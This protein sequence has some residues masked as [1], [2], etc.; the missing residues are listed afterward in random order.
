MNESLNSRFIDCLDLEK[1]REK[2]TVRPEPVGNLA[3]LD[4]LIAAD[5]F[6]SALKSI[7]IP[8]EFCLSFIKEMSTQAWLHSQSLFSSEQGYVSRIY[9]P[10]DIE[11]SPVCLTGLAGVGKSQTIAAL[12]KV[13]PPPMEFSCDHFNSNIELISYWYASARGK[14][15]GRQM[16]SDFLSSQKITSRNAA[17]LLVDCRRRVNRDG[18]SMLILEETQHISTGNGASKVTD[19][20]LTMAG[21]GPPMVY[22]SNYSLVHKLRARNNEDKQRLLS[23]PRIMLP[24]DPVGS[25][26]KKYIQECI[27]VSN[28]HLQGDLGV[29]ARDIYTATFGIKRLV[30]LLLKQA[31]IEARASGRS[32]ITVHD[33][34]AAYLSPAYATNKEDVEEL[35]KLELQRQGSRRRLDLVCPFKVPVKLKRNVVEFACSAR[36]SKVNKMVFDSSLNA[37]ERSALKEIESI[38]PKC[39]A[40]RPPKSPRIPKASDEDLVGAFHQYVESL[41]SSPKKPK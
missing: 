29:L 8:N 14:A 6:S 40:S 21:I 12:R 38:Q 32:S 5:V 28:G 2:V 17:Q 27:R 23:N 31:L 37:A 13:L 30:V 34:E 1:I 22:V 41:G 24:D 18:V 7:F 11:V 35:N 20:L 16:L 19:I 4:Y 25:D 3:D 36:D 9:S 15:G 26:W 10:P 39:A 33:L